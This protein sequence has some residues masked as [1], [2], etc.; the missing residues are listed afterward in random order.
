MKNF[1]VGH[2]P[3]RLPTAKKLLNTIQRE[4]GRSLSVDDTWTGLARPDI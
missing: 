4:F 2:V 3:L 1:D